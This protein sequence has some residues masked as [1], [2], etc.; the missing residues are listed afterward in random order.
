MRALKPAPKPHALHMKTQTQR[1]E[2]PEAKPACSLVHASQGTGS[3]SQGHSVAGTHRAVDTALTPPAALLH[4]GAHL[5]APVSRLD[6]CPSRLR[7]PSCRLRW[8][9]CCRTAAPPQPVAP[10]R[11]TACPAAARLAQKAGMLGGLSCIASDAEQRA[12]GMPARPPRAAC[13]HSAGWE[14]VCVARG[15][16]QAPAAHQRASGWAVAKGVHPCPGGDRPLYWGHTRVPKARTKAP[17]AAYL[18]AHGPSLPGGLVG[19]TLLQQPAAQPAARG[20]RA[21]HVKTR[22]TGRGQARHRR[23]VQGAVHS[24]AWLAP[25]ALNPQQ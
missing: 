5:P 16:L 6:R 20:S 21:L 12:C 19:C 9:R 2:H 14:C 18:A 1:P 3:G 24:D 13:L 10:L 17:L 22:T 25:P 23:G 7:C 4:P 8:R 15:Q 11:W